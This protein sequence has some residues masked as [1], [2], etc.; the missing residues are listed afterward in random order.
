MKKIYLDYASITPVDPRVRKEMEK[1][2]RE[3]LNPSSIHSLG[4]AAKKALDAARKGVADFVHAHPD[5]IVFTSG[6]TEANGLALEGA[7]RT[8]YRNG[9]K[10]PH[11]I[12]SG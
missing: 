5:E 2:S 8:A 7:G 12:I 11:V 10:K 6:G 3:P 1:R 4:V 9:N